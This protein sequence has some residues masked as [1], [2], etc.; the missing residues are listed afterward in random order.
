M[1]HTSAAAAAAAAAA[2]RAA[3]RARPAAAAAARPLLLRQ[4]MGQLI[5]WHSGAALVWVPCVCR[6]QSPVRRGQPLTYR[7][8]RGLVRT[9]GGY[10]RW[11]RSFTGMHSSQISL[12]SVSRFFRIVEPQVNPGSYHFHW[13]A[14]R[15]PPTG[16]PRVVQTLVLKAP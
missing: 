10:P 16:G 9:P 5:R 11:P 14:H 7:D 2:V 4:L 8:G 1:R 13:S 12:R 3:A 15:G 6:G